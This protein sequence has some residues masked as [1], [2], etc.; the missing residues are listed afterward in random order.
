MEWGKN[1]GVSAITGAVSGAIGV[2]TNQL[3]SATANSVQSTLSATSADGLSPNFQQFL[4]FIEHAIR[5][6]SNSAAVVVK[7]TGKAAEIGV[8]AQ[9]K[10]TLKHEEGV[11]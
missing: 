5:F 4:N 10:K 3:S 11:G 7:G 2:G 8:K 9:T 6:A 1:I